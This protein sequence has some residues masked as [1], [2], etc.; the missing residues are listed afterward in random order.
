LDQ[1]GNFPSP[2]GPR[3]IIL[4]IGDG[5][6]I[7]QRLGA[8]WLALG[9]D[10]LL[11]MDAMPVLG[12]QVTASRNNPI[13]DSAAAATALATGHKVNN[14]AISLDP[15]GQPLTTILEQAHAAGWAT[16]LVT[17][18]QL[19]H[20]TPAAFNAHATDRGQTLGI[21]AQLMDGDVDVLMGGGETDFT[22]P[23]V[24]GCWGGG[25]FRGDGRDL[26]AEAQAA[27]YALV[28]N[29]A[30]L[31]ALDLTGITRLL[32][33]FAEAGMHRPFTPSLEEMTAAAIA[34]LSQDPEGFFL[35]VEGGQI[36]WAGHDMDAENILFDTLGF[37]A[38]V[39]QAQVFALSRPDTLL[40][41]TADHETGGMGLNLD[42]SGGYKT[43]GPFH[44]PAGSP[45]YVTWQ[46]TSHTAQ[47]VPVTAQ[48][49]FSDLLQGSYENTFIYEVM[50]LM[51]TWE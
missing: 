5:M 13:T 42:G 11:A 24:S 19:T 50:H 36:D 51:L 17:T 44:M 29:A 16:G 15:Q 21:A 25:G 34:V 37:N 28:C 22:P 35:M 32:G 40:I 12:H 49:P 14:G 20:A 3:A 18:T 7:Y 41:V 43:D 47:D 26:V 33:L 8:Q 39:V 2:D 27:G 46:G 31:A 23:A 9:P 10:Q 45:F 6:G 38:A 1:V 30:D 48:G 4:M